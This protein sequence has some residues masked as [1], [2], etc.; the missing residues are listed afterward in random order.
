M[1]FDGEA[2][3]RRESG[4]AT[5]HGTQWTAGGFCIETPSETLIEGRPEPRTG[6]LPSVFDCTRL[7]H[8]T[9]RPR[10]VMEGEEKEWDGRERKKES[11]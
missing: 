8:S 3:A 11:V 9:V 6:M 2:L 5:I 7:S 10:G 4:S 1:A